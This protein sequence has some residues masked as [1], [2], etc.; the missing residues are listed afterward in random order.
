MFTVTNLAGEVQLKL[1]EV[2]RTV[3]LFK[4]AKGGI[5]TVMLVEDAAVIGHFTPP[6]YT[7][8]SAAV[9]PKN[10]PVMVTEPPTAADKGV[11]EVIF[12]VAV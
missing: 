2:L 9:A 1:A 12:G 10:S 6:K 3:K 11:K 7:I 4:A 8:L 5:V